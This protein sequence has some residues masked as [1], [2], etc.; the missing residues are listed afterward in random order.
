MYKKFRYKNTDVHIYEQENE[1]LR[2]SQT[3]SGLYPL[4]EY[5]VPKSKINAIINCSYF[6]PQYV[7]GRNQGDER[8]DTHDQP[9][10]YDLVFTND[11]K[12]HIGEFKSWDYTSN[13]IAGFSVATILI[14]NGKDEA[15]FS[16][17]IC[18][19]TKLSA[20]NPQTA[21]AVRRSG[22]VIFL[23]SEGR[24]SNDTGLTG[25]DVRSFFKEN[26]NDIELLCQLDGGGSSEMIVNKKIMNY[27]SDGKERA[28]LNGLA[29]V[30][31]EGEKPSEP[32]QEG[33]QVATLCFRD[34]K[35]VDMM[36]GITQGQN[37]GTHI[38]LNGANDFNGR[39]SW[40][41]VDML[42]PYDCK[43]MAIGT[44]DNTVFFESLGPVR[45]PNGVY[46]N[47]WFMATHMLDSDRKLLNIKVGKVFKQ[48]EVC[49]TE[50]HKGIGS[51]DHI[52]LEQGEGKFKG[53]SQPYYKSSDSF[54]WD[55]K[56][57]AQF[58]P[59]ATGYEHPIANMFFIKDGI[60]FTDANYKKYYPDWLTT[61]SINKPAEPEKPVEPEQP[62]DNYKEL[63][64]AEI[65]K[66]KQLNSTIAA[67][68]AE[69]ATL[70]DTIITKETEL[71]N[72]L[73]TI[74]TLEQGKANLETKLSDIA[75]CVKSLNA[76]L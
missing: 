63:Y 10:F 15:Y 40:D 58:Y 54:V 27:L 33:I 23:V 35:G 32:E 67:K 2:L 57:Y 17:A 5:F 34:Y 45:T 22:K 75:A 13:V 42:A 7:L 28:M 14:Q 60:D 39:G 16:D 12:Y 70:K 71:S 62:A 38:L 47:C 49:Y 19:A 6:T 59:N 76:L 65:A 36:S 26:Y 74:K 20:R 51:G 53:G 30:T 21:I 52:H 68:D 31:P 64:E 4:S 50:G 41:R 11:G 9:G 66:N 24:N 29:L 18:N 44:Y 72:S 56:R 55:G 8:N 69:I 61:A 37:E 46:D 43:V 73:D 3:G 48:G 1:Q 25:Y